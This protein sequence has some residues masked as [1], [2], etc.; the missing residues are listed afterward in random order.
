MDILLQIFTYWP[1]FF[2]L[3]TISMSSPLISLSHL[4]VSGTI[5]NLASEL[6]NV[7][8]PDCIYNW[9]VNSLS[10]RQHQNKRL[11]VVSP[12]R[13][14]NASIIPGSALG[15]TECLHIFW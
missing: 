10:D 9:I 4:T 1:T 11:D 3:M 13:P 5:H 8:M 6:A 14:I 7:T 2:S 12:T 15:P